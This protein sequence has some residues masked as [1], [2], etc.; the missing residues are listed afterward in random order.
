MIENK[1]TFILGAGAS[2]PFGLPLGNGLVKIIKKSLKGA[3][4][5]LESKFDSSS[6]RKGYIDLTLKEN[7]FHALLNQLGHSNDEISKFQE[8]LEYMELNSIDAFLEYRTEFIPIGKKVIAYNLLKYE[9]HEKLYENSNWYKYIWNEMKCP[10]DSFDQNQISFIT[11]NYDRTLEY[12]L[13]NAMKALYGKSEEECFKQ[14]KKIPIIHVHGKLGNL[15]FEDTS[16]NISFGEKI[17]DK[18]K[19]IKASDSI[20]IIHED[21][22]E[23]IKAFDQAASLLE[24]ADKVYCLGFG[25]GKTNLQRLKINVLKKRVEGTGLGLTA[26]ERNSI[27]TGFGN[28]LIEKIGYDSLEF[29]RE[30]INFKKKNLSGWVI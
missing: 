13:I 21:F 3:E 25:Y 14:L 6:I 7:K 27:R 29:I 18:S 12:Y 5:D 24:K 11:F 17:N 16:N 26:N 2:H 9:S 23:E 8:S 19:L 10:F 30:K 22:G 28:L 15:P 20:K 4:D 1:I